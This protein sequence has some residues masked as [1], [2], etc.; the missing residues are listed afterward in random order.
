MAYYGLEEL[1]RRIAEHVTAERGTF[2]E[3]GAFDGI[4]QNNTL[5]FEERGWRG[6]LIEPLPEAY[7]ACVRNRPAAQVFNCACVPFDHPGQEIR[8]TA[9]GL[10]SVLKDAFGN[11]HREAEWI[12]RAES[13]QNLQRREIVV[14]TRTLDS[15]LIEANLPCPD[16]LVL[17]VEGAEIDVLRGLDLARH[18]PRFIVCEDAYSDAPRD[19]LARAGYVAKAT[20]LERRF[21]R[22][23]LYTDRAP[24]TG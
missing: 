16:L 24:S 2:V 6:A 5:H 23:I 9:V 12:A 21:T 13:L 15:I 14:P 10:M 8:M 18:R 3:L 17:D 19:F 4:T 7:T 20:L 1:D 22:D 11:P